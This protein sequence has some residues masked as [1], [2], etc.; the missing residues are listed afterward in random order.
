[1]MSEVLRFASTAF[2]APGGADLPADDIAD[3][4]VGY[5]FASLELN[6]AH[7]KRRAHDL[8]LTGAKQDIDLAVIAGR[9]HAV[10]ML[11]FPAVRHTARCRPIHVR[12]VHMRLCARI[13]CSSGQ[14]HRNRQGE[15]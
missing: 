9:D 8:R 11:P 10:I 15:I 7:L 12:P 13:G 6:I 3:I 2:A 1:M 14:Q 5:L 4:D